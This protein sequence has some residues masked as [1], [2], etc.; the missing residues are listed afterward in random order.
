ME[1]L[2]SFNP[3]KHQS[4][5]KKERIQ[6]WISQGAQASDTVQNM[7]IKQG[8]IKGKKVSVHKVASKAP[9][10]AKPVSS[11]GE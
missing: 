8:I 9:E 1:I 7:L 2:G 5:F 10:K 3:V 11:E 6:Y 4:V